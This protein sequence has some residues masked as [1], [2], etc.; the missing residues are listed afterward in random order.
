MS[1]AWWNAAPHFTQDASFLPT[2]VLSDSPSRI[3]LSSS[4]SMTVPPGAMAAEYLVAI[5]SVDLREF[6]KT[7]H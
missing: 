7:M 6:T 1:P 5:A 4:D 3:P 2:A